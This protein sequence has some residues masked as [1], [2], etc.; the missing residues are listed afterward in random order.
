[1][2]PKRF[3]Y[4]PSEYVFE[5]MSGYVIEL[6]EILKSYGIKV[7]GSYNPCNLAI[8]IKAM[9]NGVEIFSKTFYNVELIIPEKLFVKILEKYYTS[10]PM[11]ESV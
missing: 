10:I 6:N 5:T 3:F 11:K 4:N 7:Y 8:T 9:Y 2:M 1:M